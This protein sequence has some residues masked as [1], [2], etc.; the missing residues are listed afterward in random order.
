MSHRA[1]HSGVPV[2]YWRSV[3]HSHNAFFSESFIDEMAVHLGRD[4]LEFRRALLTG[5]PRHLAVLNLAALKAGWGAPLPQ[6]HAHGLALHES[7]GTIVA[8]V[9]EVSI[10]DAQPRVHSVVCAVDCGTVINPDIV[11]Q[12]MEGAVVF[13]LTAALFGQIDIRQGAV[14]Q[15]NF[16]EYPML[17][18]GQVPRV[19]TWIVESTRAPGGVGEPGVPPI[20]PAVSNALFVLTGQRQRSLPLRV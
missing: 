15:R 9:A 11:A 8:Q 3:G 6:G 13:G 4:P 16:S 7:F 12:Q 19:Q 17:S 5:S 2:G 20:A 10:Q 18:M 1:T 14:V